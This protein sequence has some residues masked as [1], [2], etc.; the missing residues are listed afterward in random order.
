[1]PTIVGEARVC[2]RRCRSRLPWRPWP[3]PAAPQPDPR[4]PPP[5]VCVCVRARARACMRVCVRARV[6]ACACVNCAGSASR[7]L[8][9]VCRTRMC[10]AQAESWRS[11]IDG[12]A[13]HASPLRPCCPNR[14][15]DGHTAE[16]YRGLARSRPP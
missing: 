3:L 14:V 11:G 13:M 16:P 2:Y 12:A 8:P 4:R 5:L 9:S 6:R 10:P 1:M 7:P 15:L